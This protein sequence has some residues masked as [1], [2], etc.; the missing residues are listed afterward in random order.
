MP[1]QVQILFPPTRVAAIPRKQSP[2]GRTR[3]GFK[4]PDPTDFHKF[5]SP[6]HC[7]QLRWHLKSPGGTFD[8]HLRP[9]GLFW[10]CSVGSDDTALALKPVGAGPLLGSTV[11]CPHR[12][13]RQSPM[14]SILVAQSGGDRRSCRRDKYGM[15]WRGLER[16][17]A[18]RASSSRSRSSC[19]RCA[20][21]AS[22]ALFCRARVAMCEDR[23]LTYAESRYALTADWLP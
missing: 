13:R 17:A 15:D 6:V 14:V 1:S 2:S 3:V 18:T 16:A 8:V 10:R 19:D 23:R 21:G 22:A 9:G 20:S 11:R 12:R 7:N 5:S 4:T